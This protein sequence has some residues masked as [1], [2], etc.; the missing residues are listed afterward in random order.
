MSEEM[1]IAAT[2]R[3]ARIALD[4]G[5]VLR[6]SPEVEHERTV[7][8]SDLLETNSFAPLAADGAVLARGPYDVF[9]SIAD[10]RLN[11]LV[12]DMADEELSRVVLPLTPFRSVI[13]DY[14]LICES[15]FE[16][17]KQASVQR[18]E[19][20]DMARRGLH[21]EGS[22]I[23]AGLLRERVQVDFETARRLF[24]LICVLHIKQ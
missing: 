24:T 3:I 19:A 8:L 21:N 18:V 10:N 5:K 15:Y 11:L 17:I 20:I 13:R 16:A 1:T 9:L 7:A 23:L 22:E 14:F 6:R 4:E 2:E 12:K